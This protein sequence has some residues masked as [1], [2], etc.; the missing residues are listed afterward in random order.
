MDKNILVYIQEKGETIETVSLELLGKARELS[1]K[2]G[3]RIYA[4][5]FGM[6][7]E[8][9]ARHLW[10]YPAEKLFYFEM[11]EPCLD[12]NMMADMAAILCQ[13]IKPDIFLLGATRLGR[14]LAPCIA[15][16]LGTGLT[17][18]C[19]ELHMDKELL[20][21]R[22]AFEERMLAYI[23]TRTRPQ[24]ATV[25]PGVMKL[26]EVDREGMPL[27]VIEHIGVEKQGTIPGVYEILSK[28][29][30]RKSEEVNI[31][32]EKILVVA[33]AGVTVQEEIDVLKQWAESIGGTI[34]CSRKLVERGWFTVERQVGLSG[35]ASRAEV[36]VAVGVSGSVQFQAGIH[37]VK[38]LIAINTDQD[39][40][41]MALADESILSDLHPFIQK[42]KERLE[43]K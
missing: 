25:R 34:A 32:E 27:P 4:I 39:A 7:A 24:M 33:G 19:T 35:N 43:S 16:R 22:P 12:V 40:P 6:D 11:R 5:C 10:G 9:T 8:K 29:P 20:Q 26:P 14:G 28:K 21:V 30:L 41:I 42:L 18:D 36:M 31:T 3:F 37:N 15:A 2:T 23:R 17:A 13:R 38:H 1:L